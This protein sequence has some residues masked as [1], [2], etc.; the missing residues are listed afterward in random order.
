MFNKFMKT[1]SNMHKGEKGMTGLETAIILIAF[2]T[3]AAVFG[4]AVLSAGLFSAERGKETVYAGLAEAK[5]NLEL[6]GSVIGLGDNVSQSLLKIK[7][8]LK[9]AI[10]GN[11]I[12]LTECDGTSTAQ[13][14]CVISMT[15]KNDYFNNVKW[16]KEAIG[17]ADA[18]NL[19]ET[20]EQFEVTVDMGD[21][22]VGKALSENL[23]VNDQFNIQVKPSVGSTMT[24][25]RQ[26]PP[27]IEA[28]MD[29]H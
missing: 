19:L 22:G 15:T 5:S 16:T 1:L 20:G 4:Y 27:A 21:L 29:L 10:A 11:P 12:D 9:N 26:L 14:K 13:N 17:A 8:T 3:V 7:F 23:T 18:D 24:I 25:Q 28:V 6:S 2:V